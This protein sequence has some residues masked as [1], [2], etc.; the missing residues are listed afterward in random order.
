MMAKAKTPPPNLTDV[1]AK[2][3]VSSSNT[4]SDA[5]EMATPPNQPT[6]QYATAEDK[7]AAQIVLFAFTCG[8]FSLSHAGTV[9]Q[10]AKLK[11]T[12]PTTSQ[13]RGPIT[14]RGAG[15]DS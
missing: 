14:A 10:K 5:R 3:D 8:T 13:G 7:H 12:T 1:G 2:D 15:R 4:L 6:K 9:T 11:M